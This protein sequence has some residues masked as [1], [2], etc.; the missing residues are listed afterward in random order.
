MTSHTR[1]VGLV[2]ILLGTANCVQAP[3]P[4]ETQQASPT[5]DIAYEA[6]EGPFKGMALFIDQGSGE[7]WA[8]FR[9]QREAVSK[10]GPGT[11]LVTCGQDTIGCFKDEQRP[12]L[13]STL[14][15]TDFL[16]GA[17]RYGARPTKFWA[18][19][20]NEIEAAATDVATKSTV[21]PVIGLVQFSYWANGVQAERYQLKSWAGLFSQR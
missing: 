7:T 10:E 19:S 18:M 15:P 16:D 12:P 9:D 21:C 17:F 14:P 1:I 20:C 5:Y 6:V 11:R 4:S 3:P 8:A 13:L 2:T